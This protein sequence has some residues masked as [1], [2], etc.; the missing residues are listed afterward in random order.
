MSDLDDDFDSATILN[1]ALSLTQARQDLEPVM[2]RSIV[3]LMM[4]GCVEDRVAASFLT[5]LYQKGEA[6]GELVG[7]A[8]AMREYMTPIVTE[9]KNVIDTCGTGGG[10]ANTFNISTAV[11]IVAAAAG[12]NVAKHGNKKSTS[13]SGSSDVLEVLGVNIHAPV[14]LVSE[15]LNELGICFCFAPLFHPSVK[16]IMEVRRQLPFPTVFNLL[17]PLCNPA[18]APF[19]LLGAGRGETQ[20][21]LAGA[22]FQLGTRSSWV[23]H[24]SNGLGELSI[25]NESVIDAISSNGIRRF[26]LTPEAVGLSRQSLDSIIVESPEQSAELIRRVLN[27][28]AGPSRDIVL[29]NAGAA[30]HLVGLA[31]DLKSGTQLAADALTAGKPRE[32][33]EQLVA[34]TN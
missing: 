23:V 12:A 5:N 22:L 8:Q 15:C 7:A 28:E 13:R 33:L 6:V 26:T 11:A 31:D 34:F 20:N 21:L 18:L 27:N 10:G 29:M 1:E 32:L 2:M 16:R 24:S 3:R 9:R 19:Q 17:G 4:S 30:L 14:E 25:A